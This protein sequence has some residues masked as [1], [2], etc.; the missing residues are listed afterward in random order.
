M[1]GL[2]GRGLVAERWAGALAF[3]LWIPCLGGG[4]ESR[5]EARHGALNQGGLAGDRLEPER[6]SGWPS[7]EG[8][9]FLV[10]LVKKKKK[11]AEENAVR[12]EEA[13]GRSRWCG[14]SFCKNVSGLS[15]EWF[16][17]EEDYAF[18]QGAY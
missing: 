2:N 10:I 17:E 18:F 8:A 11:P 6:G 5:R 12:A 13:C 9:P 15:G 14:P 16:L 4:I 1:W 7:R 3:A